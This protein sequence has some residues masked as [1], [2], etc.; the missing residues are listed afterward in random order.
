MPVSLAD[1]LRALPDPELA[2]LIALRPDLVMPVPGDISALALRAQSRLSVAR[3]LDSLDRFTLEVLDV[4]RLTR[5]PETATTSVEAVLMLT[6]ESRV[7]AGP[8]REALDRLRA[9]ALVYGSDP[10]LHLVAGVDEVCSPY[11]AG[12]GRPAADLNTDAAVLVSDP[13]RLRRTVLA[14]PPA[15][16]AVLDRLADGPPVGTVAASALTDPES[17]SPVRWLVD[18]H[19]LVPIGVDTVE[20]PREVSLLL[21]RETGPL[22]PL[23][24][25]PPEIEAPERQVSMVDRAGAGQAMEVARHAEALADVLAAEPAPVLRSGGVGVRELRR[26]AR[27]TGLDEPVAALLLEVAYAAG[28]LGESGGETGDA[29]VLPA[30]GFDAWRVTSLA[31]RWARLA[32]GWL[33]MRRMPSLVGQRDDRDRLLPVLS[34]DIERVGAPAQRR[35]ALGVLASLP[36][37]AAPSA[38][39]VRAVLSWQ[40]PRRVVR[41]AASAG[42]EAAL[43]EA[44]TLGLTGLGALTSY[45]R[46]L[47][48][49]VEAA[50]RLDPDADPLGISAGAPPSKAVEALDALLPAPVD[51]VLV[52]ADLTVVVPGPPEPGLAAELALV[53]DAE[54]ASVYRVTADSVRRALDTGYAAADLHSLFGR[55]SRTPVPQALTYLVDDVSRRHGGLRAGSAGGYL[56]GDDE[57]LLAEVLADRRLAALGLRRLAPTVLISPYAP[58]RLLAALR[59]AGYSPVPEDATGAAVLTRP[60]PPR[61]AARPS[62][63]SRRVDDPLAGARLTP[64]RLAGIVEQLRRS[65]AAVRAASRAPAGVRS[66]G[67]T[68]GLTGAQAHTQAMAVLQQALREK[69]RVWVGYV[70]AHGATNSRLVRPVSMG[71][72]YL[73]AEDERTE[74]LHTFALHRI[75]AAVPEEASP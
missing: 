16:R 30:A 20:L 73:R 37:G 5:T 19:L 70:D 71:A 36:P 24:P 41:A 32:S 33:L 38:D 62:V 64:A 63:P 53:A 72:G 25:A 34:A 43:A 52:Q 60:R 8:V 42:H 75:T 12:L 67:G 45:G 47:L 54:S 68:A 39:D 9:L 18:H 51:H 57:A 59:E 49:E 61:A 17:D 74:M 31:Q 4:V 11:P 27:A 7:A 56:R 10:A 3:T 21:R 1:H 48:A 65:D 22:G 58:N 13:T 29:V 35:E 55:R 69:S 40:A 6:A 26:L 2:A 44:A 28:L 50:E 15:A 46:S 23:H 66:P 14:A